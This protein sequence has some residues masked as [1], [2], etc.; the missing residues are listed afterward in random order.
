MVYFLNNAMIK[1]MQDCDIVRI[2]CNGFNLTIYD[3]VKSN[4]VFQVFNKSAS[5]VLISLVLL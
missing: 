2:F 5:Q 3:G 1:E 4:F